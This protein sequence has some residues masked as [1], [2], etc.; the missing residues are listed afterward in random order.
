MGTTVHLKTVM[1]DYAKREPAA[2]VAVGTTTFTGDGLRMFLQFGEH[3]L[4]LSDGDAAALYQAVV[5][6]ATALDLPNEPSG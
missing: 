6:V 2:K 4:I 1:Q 5:R 3:G